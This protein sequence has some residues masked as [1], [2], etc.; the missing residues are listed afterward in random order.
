MSR[1]DST[2][3]T[4]DEKI[5]NIKFKIYAFPFFF[6]LSLYAI[7]CENSISV[8]RKD[9]KIYFEGTTRRALMRCRSF[10]LA[11]WKLKGSSRSWINQ[12]YRR[13]TI[14]LLRLLSLTEI[15]EIYGNRSQVRQKPL[16][17]SVFCIKSSLKYVT[18]DNVSQN[19]IFK[20]KFK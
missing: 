16:G 2:I 5:T 11:H 13:R 12:L 9:F 1:I 19:F 20:R 7:K 3:Y 6:I 10:V 15:P 14:D 4:L 18:F 8:F 17:S